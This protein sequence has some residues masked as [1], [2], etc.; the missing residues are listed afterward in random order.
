MLSGCPNPA[1]L[2]WRNGRDSPLSDSFRMLSHRRESH[3]VSAA[4]AQHAHSSSQGLSPFEWQALL[5][6]PLPAGELRG[7]QSMQRLRWLESGEAAFNR[8]E[9]ARD[10]VAVVTGTV[11]LGQ[12]R[13]DASFDLQRNVHGPQWLDL[14]SAWLGGG[15][16]QD[17]VALGAARVLE[18]PVAAMRELLLR[19][20]ALGERLLA[21]LAHT[22]RNLASL[23]HDL[24]YKDAERRLAVWLLRRCAPV[25]EE[26]Q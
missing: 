25:G 17:A 21:G 8:Q 16:G 13:E 22:V 9:R 11:G 5:G 23:S 12:R 18:L 20:T 24:V 10:L 2:T 3:A 6:S 19:E 14:S 26:L 1:R 4:E 7:L 15:H